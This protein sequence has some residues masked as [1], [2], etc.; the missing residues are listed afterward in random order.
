VR[1]LWTQASRPR[2]LLVVVA[3]S[4]VTLAASSPISSAVRGSRATGPVSGS[5]TARA[6][7]TAATA[8]CSKAAANEVVGRLHLN[9]PSVA[10]PVFKVLCGAFTGPGSETMVAS[11][12]GPGNTG[13]ID[14]A[15][16]RWA[17]GEWQFLMKRHQAAV[18][19]AAGS[20]IRE[21]VSIYRDGDSRCCPSGGTKARNWHWNGTQFTAGPWKQVTPGEAIEKRF[22]SPSGNINCWMFDDT[23]GAGVGCQSRKS[24]RRV[25][26]GGDGR[27]KIC[28][29]IRC[30]GCGCDA[31]ATPTL[32][33]GRQ[34]SVGRF[35]CFSQ[36]AGVKCIVIR[37]GKGFLINNN[38][39]TRVG[40]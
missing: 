1:Q 40:P 35:R 20:D 34:I 10:D 28:R 25:N 33:Y 5:P 36:R 21:T 24:P 32:G 39:V 2:L 12:F 15:A 18:L 9:D 26:M 23:R 27:L 31:P 17:A 14:W 30:V 16:F 13:M 11:L 22:H 6:G 37:S 19:T 7:G 38:G 8:D 4:V 29:G 3:S